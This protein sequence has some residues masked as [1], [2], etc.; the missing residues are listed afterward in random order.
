MKRLTSITILTTAEGKRISATYSDID[1][2]GKI[3]SENNRVNRIVVDPDALKLISGLEDYAQKI[4]EKS[5][6]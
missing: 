6:E 1:N 5:M 3:V 2:D 4:I